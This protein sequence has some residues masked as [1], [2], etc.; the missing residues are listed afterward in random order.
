VH[1]Y[2]IIIGCADK[3][4]PGVYSRISSQYDWIK[5]QVCNLSVRP[6]ESFN[7]NGNG[8]Q[9]NVVDTVFWTASP[10]GS[11]SIT[12][13]PTPAPTII[14]EEPTISPSTLSPTRSPLEGGLKRILIVLKLDDSPEDTGWKLSTTNENQVVYEAPAG[15]YKA[16]QADSTVEYEFEVEGE[17]FYHLT[18]Y[19]APGNGFSGTMAVYGNGGVISM[20][21]MLVQEPG[22]SRVSGT[23]VKHGFYVG[24]NPAQIVT[25]RLKFDYYPNEVAYE[26]RNVN[27]NITMGLAWFETFVSGTKNMVVKIP[28]Y[29]PERGNQSYEFQIWDAGEDGICCTFGQGKYQ[30][31]LGPIVD[32]VLLT[33]GGDFELT[34]TF[35]FDIEGDLVTSSPT[36]PP[37]TPVPILSLPLDTPKSPPSTPTSAL[38]ELAQNPIPPSTTP[39]DNSTVDTPTASPQYLRSPPEEAA[40]NSN[41]VDT[42]SA[43][44]RD[45]NASQMRQQ[46]WTSSVLILA[47]CILVL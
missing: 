2:N 29:G 23:E 39:T 7:C 3:N 34:E 42:D 46:L 30:L 28:V 47:G 31:Y 37:A 12:D 13:E 24:D 44:T 16:N 41:D 4:F 25:L 11:V 19:D 15:Q 27:N 36:G 5:E 1:L 33:N 43:E 45:A 17:Q 32:Q 21:S 38:L 10:A 6:P 26:L 9:T 18:I 40:I 14:T 35:A 20:Q 8:I 22:F